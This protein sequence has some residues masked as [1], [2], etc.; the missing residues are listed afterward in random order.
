MIRA[1]QNYIIKPPPIPACY[2]DGTLYIAIAFFGSVTAAMGSDE[3]AKW[4]APVVLFWIRS[5]AGI[6]SACVLALKMFR[7]TAFSEHLATLKKNGDTQIFTRETP[8]EPKP[9]A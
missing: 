5:V 4:V 9:G 7:S 2:I 3:A 6:L 8:P 1:I